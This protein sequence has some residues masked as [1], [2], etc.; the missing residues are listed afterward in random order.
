MFYVWDYVA[1]IPWKVGDPD[2]DDIGEVQIVV[3]VVS[4][5]NYLGDNSEIWSFIA[6]VEKYN[7]QEIQQMFWNS[8]TKN[9]GLTFQWQ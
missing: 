6:K 8:E 5:V 4:L 3:V 1:K 9:E 2:N 7:N